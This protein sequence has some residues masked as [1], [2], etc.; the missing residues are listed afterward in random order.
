MRGSRRGNCFVL[1]LTPR[2]RAPAEIRLLFITG[3]PRRLAARFSIS[4]SSRAMHITDV[5]AGYALS[6][7]RNVS[8]TE[9]PLSI[10][11]STVNILYKD[12]NFYGSDSYDRKI[13][14]AAVCK[15]LCVFVFPGFYGILL[16]R[17]ARCNCHRCISAYKRYGGV[18]LLRCQKN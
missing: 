12:G 17:A 5:T 18:Y 4:R 7:L 6:L 16:L 14:K 9:Y 2:H 13:R 10:N 11:N 1:T 15:S 8:F 3:Q